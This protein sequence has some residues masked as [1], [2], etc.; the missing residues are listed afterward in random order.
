[1]AASQQQ[2]DE[3]EHDEEDVIPSPCRDATLDA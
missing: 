1:M 3:S 2:Q